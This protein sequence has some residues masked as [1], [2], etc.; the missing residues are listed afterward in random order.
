MRAGKAWLWSAIGPTVFGAVLVLV[1]GI[2]VMGALGKNSANN[3]NAAADQA[4]SNMGSCEITSTGA[5][6]N[7]ETAASSSAPSSAAAQASA[8]AVLAAA[9]SSL[10]PS[11]LSAAENA[12]G[13]HL[14]ATQVQVA[15]VIVGVGK[16]VG[17]DH[18]GMEVA[19]IVAQTDSGFNPSA[20]INSGQIAGVF[21]QLASQYPGVNLLDP[22]AASTSFYKYLSNLAEYITPSTDVG[23][24]AYMMQKPLSPYGLGSTAEVYSGKA[25]WAKTLVLLLDTG[26]PPPA[27]NAGQA[28]IN[29]IT[30]LATVAVPGLTP[31]QAHNAQVIV[32]V[33]Q[34]RKLSVQAQTIAVSVAIAES[35]LLNYANDGTSTDMGYF[36][37]GHR[38]LNAQE[39][40]VARESMALPH[41]AVGHNLDSMGLFQ[42][43]PSASW[44]TPAQLMDPATSAGKFYDVLITIAGYNT[45]TTPYMVAQQVQGSNDAGGGIYATTYPQAQAIVAALAKATPTTT[46]GGSGTG[47]VIVNGPKITLPAKAGIA[48]T[49]TAPNAQVAKVI[50]AGLNWL[51]EPYSYAGGSPAGP[52]LGACSDDPDDLG[53]NDCHVVGFDCSGLMLYMWAQV[54]VTLPRYSQDQWS[55]GTQIPFAQALPGDLLGYPHHITTYL[56]KINGVD[57]MIEAPQSGE[58][59]HVTPV[60]EGHYATVGRVWK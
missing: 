53:R 26:V 17:M 39:R 16:T 45:S 9:T 23:R 18:R 47:V 15:Q 52:T 19:L 51:G 7:T 8:S 24:V 30:G 11:A 37:H 58:F 43:R 34:A 56:G 35:T 12:T 32:A 46:T 33:G 2:G 3:A 6:G 21:H 10:A 31:E 57:Y 49:I 25:A 50:S 1:I 38:E 28:G 54:G 59:V 36:S 14:T 29:C 48:A 4:G 20:S 55:S 5:A 13:F 42:Q 60:R 27:S 41:E 22:V 44:G 40:A